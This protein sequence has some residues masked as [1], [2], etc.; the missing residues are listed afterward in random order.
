M[1]EAQRDHLGLE[2]ETM[3]NELVEVYITIPFPE[4]RFDTGRPNR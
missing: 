2:I 4:H 3:G 1:M